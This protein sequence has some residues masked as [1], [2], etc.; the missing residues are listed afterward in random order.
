[1][2]PPSAVYADGRRGR[3]RV[4]VSPI[5]FFLLAVSYQE[6]LHRSFFLC[7]PL[8]FTII[9]EFILPLPGVVHNIYAASFSS[10]SSSSS[11]AAAANGKGKDK[12]QPVE[13]GG[14]QSQSQSQENG[15]DAH[16]G[17]ARG[18]RRAG[19]GGEEVDE[20]AWTERLLTVLKY[21]DDKAHPSF[22]VY[23]NLQGK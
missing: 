17:G 7:R 21:M 22:L 6:C 20:V 12:A 15:L 18:G 13:E 14:S 9:A 8:L 23:C 2:D 4:E 1:M 16:E 19:A 5:N 10:S 11:G 3:H